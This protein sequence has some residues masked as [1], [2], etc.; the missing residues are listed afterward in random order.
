MPQIFLCHD[1]VDF[2]KQTVELAMIVEREHDSFGG[3]LSAFTNRQRN[4][5]RCKIR[6]RLI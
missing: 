3:G 5:G 4:K 2:R 1:P 6:D